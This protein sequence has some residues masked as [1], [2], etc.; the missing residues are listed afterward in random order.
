MLAARNGTIDP[1]RPRE[2]ERGLCME[3]RIKRTIKRLTPEELDLR[4]EALR[5]KQVSDSILDL[6]YQKVMEKGSK[7][8]EL[9][10]EEG[11]T[12]I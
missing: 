12:D 6:I 4:E 2:Q 11:L 5:R 9:K 3:P 1:D 7:K 10:T 8:K